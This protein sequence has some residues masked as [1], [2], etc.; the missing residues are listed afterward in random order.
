MLARAAYERVRIRASGPRLD[1][2][3]SFAKEFPA[4][5][6]SCG[7]A[8][9]LAFALAK[10]GHQADYSNDLAVVLDGEQ[11]RGVTLAHRSR[12]LN[13]TDYLRLSH[14]ALRAAVWLKRYVEAVAASRTN[15]ATSRPA[16]QPG[17]AAGLTPET[18]ASEGQS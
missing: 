9:A 16:E 8:Q 2:Y 14:D 5:I 1:E 6:H 11:S 3:S 17:S 10:G 15:G 4:L 18:A 12:T 7:L 13:V